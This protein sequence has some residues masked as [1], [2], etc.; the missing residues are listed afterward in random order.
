[1]DF[2]AHLYRVCVI[3]SVDGTIITSFCVHECEGSSRMGSRPRRVLFT[4]HSNG[5]VQIWDLSTALDLSTRGEPLQPIGGPTP[6]ELMRALEQCE[7]VASRNSTPVPTPN[8]GTVTTSLNEM[9]RI[10]AANMPLLMQLQSA[11][12]EPLRNECSE[13]DLDT[14]SS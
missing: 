2:T 3:K 4:G 9:P 7:I 13:A 1:M 11:V 12:R 14:A 8:P 6:F 10:K 5:I